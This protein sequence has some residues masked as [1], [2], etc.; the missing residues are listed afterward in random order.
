M[1]LSISHIF[2]VTLKAVFALIGLLVL[3]IVVLL[4]YMELNSR[5][6]SSP[7]PG[8]EKRLKYDLDD[9]PGPKSTT[10]S[11]VNLW[12]G[13]RDGQYDTTHLRIGKD[14]LGIRGHYHGEG[15]YINT[16]WPSL[17]SIYEYGRTREKDG[18]PYERDKEFTLVLTE[19]K[20]A[21]S[22]D[23][24]GTAS[25]FDCE[26]VIRDEARGVK[27]CNENRKIDSSVERF[28]NYWPLDETIR[29]PWYKNPPKAHCY[30]VDRAGEKH[31][32]ACSI[33]FSY[34]TDV[35]V[36]ML[37]VHEQLAIEIISEFTRLTKFLST[38]EVK[39]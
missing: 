11:P 27:Y 36:T 1:N 26:P 24:S 16:V 30:I 14:Y 19:A 28:T 39:S 13:R 34:N 4:G 23:K 6:P 7:P 29:T 38:L 33:V 37:Y 17:I 35:D 20:P 2:G 9:P 31:F 5:P 10:K 3:L 8:F 25:F 12:F 21:G 22:G 32:D 18:L 15:V